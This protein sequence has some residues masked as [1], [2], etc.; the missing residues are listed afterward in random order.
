[1][2]VKYYKEQWAREHKAGVPPDL[3]ATWFEK[4]YFLIFKTLCAYFLFSE[5]S[6]KA[7][8]FTFLMIRIKKERLPSLVHGDYDSGGVERNLEICCAVFCFY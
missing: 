4:Y 5:K 8:L 7:L 2:L 1:M 3:L 6:N